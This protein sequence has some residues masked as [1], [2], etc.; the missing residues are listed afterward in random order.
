MYRGSA[1]VLDT[2]INGTISY[3]PPII[4]VEKVIKN[5]MKLHITFLQYLKYSHK[6]AD[7]KIFSKKNNF[8]S[9]QILQSVF[10]NKPGPG[11]NIHQKYERTKKVSMQQKLTETLKI[12]KSG[13]RLL[14][15]MKSS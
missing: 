4:R 15:W 13:T 1:R 5:Y 14:I 3:E 10:S 11:V 8:V 9:F 7:L 2:V 6:I 12:H